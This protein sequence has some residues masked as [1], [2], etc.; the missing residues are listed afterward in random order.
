MGRALFLLGALVIIG[1]RSFFGR[2]VFFM[3]YL[4]L[5][6]DKCQPIRHNRSMVNA[7]TIAS[8]LARYLGAILQV[9]A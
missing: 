1:R 7:L 2:A 3:R 8:T 5:G 6:V 9:I 4:G